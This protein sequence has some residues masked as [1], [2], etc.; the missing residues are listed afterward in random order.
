VDRLD[1]AW[2]LHE[3]LMERERLTRRERIAAAIF[4]AYH[5][6]PLDRQFSAAHAL[7][8]ADELIAALD[9]RD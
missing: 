7:E 5:A 3:A 4:A 9:R 6:G 2:A 8:Q 1:L